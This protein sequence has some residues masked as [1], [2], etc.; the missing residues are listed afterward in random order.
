MQVAHV[1]RKRTLKDTQYYNSISRARNFM[2]DDIEKGLRLE[3]ET[4]SNDDKL[5]GAPNFL[6]ALGL[7]CYTE[8][9]GKLVLGIGQK[10]ERGKSK[11]KH[12][13]ET[14]LK[15][16]DRDYYTNLLQRKKTIYKDVRCGLAHMYLIE[17]AHAKV[18]TGE[19]GSHGI[20]Y[21]PAQNNKLQGEYIFWVR[22]YFVE[23]R[24][25]V[26]SYISDLTEGKEDLVHKLERSL[27]GRPILI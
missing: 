3:N 7:C 13:F 27:N 14:F 10:Q 19:S 12:S 2:I 8:Y 5:V 21:Y 18:D 20:E 17:N 6:L 16:M 4:L 1:Y 22:K 11:S 9:W 25:A 15:M 26:D 23:F 24:T